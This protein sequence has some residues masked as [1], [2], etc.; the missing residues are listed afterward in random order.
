M[1]SQ[2]DFSAMDPGP[3][4]LAVLSLQGAFVLLARG[5]REP[6]KILEEGSSLFK[7]QLSGLEALA[8]GFTLPL[9]AFEQTTQLL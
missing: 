5:T 3:P 4:V 7:V 2:S 8:P 1:T 6:S 9:A